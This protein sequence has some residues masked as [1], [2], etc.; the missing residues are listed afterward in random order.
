MNELTPAHWQSERTAYGAWY[1]AHAPR[2]SDSHYR[3]F[4]HARKR[5]IATGVGC[6]RCGSKEHLEAHHAQCEFAVANGVDYTK[7]AA[8]FPEYHLDS[9]EAFLAWVE[10]EGNLLMLCADCHRGPTGIH[11]VP[12][13]CWVWQRWARTGIASA[14]ALP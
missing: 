5:L 12:Y 14:R 2:E 10:S 3:L 4:E 7:L 8:D 1:P 9:E 11:H 13:P 6:W